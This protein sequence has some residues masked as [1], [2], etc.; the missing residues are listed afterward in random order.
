MT[1]FHPCSICQSYS[2]ASFYHCAL[3][4]VK[5]DLAFVRLRYF[6]GGDRPSQ[7]T[8]H[9]LSLKKLVETNNQSGHSPVAFALPPNKLHSLFILTIQNHSKGAR[10]LSV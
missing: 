1:D 9:K 8:F 2:Q 5:L 3:Q 6:L 4:S 10:G 7:T